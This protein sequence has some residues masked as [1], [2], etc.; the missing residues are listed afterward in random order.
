M[1]ID[2]FVVIITIILKTTFSQVVPLTH[3]QYQD[4]PDYITSFC[5]TQ[6]TDKI[7]N[8]N[9][10]EYCIIVYYYNKELN[11]QYSILIR[12]NLNVECSDLS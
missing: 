10:I 2:N 1:F 7:L 4:N 3:I 6:H 12:R 5:L 9:G 11:L 8:V